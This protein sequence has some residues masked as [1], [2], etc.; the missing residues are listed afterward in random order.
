MTDEQARRPADPPAEGQDAEIEGGLTED[1]LEGEEDVE[2]GVAAEE[3]ADFPAETPAAP[4][5]DAPPAGSA[6]RGA[7]RREGGYRGSLAPRNDRLA[8]PWVIAVIALFVLMLLLA[9]VGVPS[10][11][12]PEPSGVPLPSVPAPSV[13]GAP[14]P[15]SSVIAS[16]P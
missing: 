5:A 3:A 9:A 8:R 6:P 15:S 11:L 13:S 12:F 10:R 4:A 7:P 2:D 14:V 1:E 16:P